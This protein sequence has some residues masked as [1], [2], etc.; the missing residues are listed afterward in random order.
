MSVARPSVVGMQ[1]L[2]VGD[3]DVH[4]TFRKMKHL[5]LRIDDGKVHLSAPHGTPTSALRDFTQN[6]L[7]WIQRALVRDADRPQPGR[8]NVADGTISLW[9]R[10]VPLTQSAGKKADARWC[11]SEVHV[12]YPL[13]DEDAFRKAL[14]RFLAKELRPVAQRLLGTYAD[15]MG[16]QPTDLRVRRMKSR[17]GSCKPSTG[18]ITLNTA[19][20]ELDPKALECVVVHELAHLQTPN[21]GPDFRATMNTFLPG[22]EVIQRDYLRR[23]T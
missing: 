18:A 21:H 20:A 2:H 7:A 15:K 4:V 22:W 1:I 13:G 17:W 19:L 14:D 3:H 16:V 9:G 6:N 11:G 10:T 12:V 23:K 8:A 5:R